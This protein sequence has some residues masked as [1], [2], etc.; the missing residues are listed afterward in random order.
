MPPAA[1]HSLYL[2]LLLTAGASAAEG[3]GSAAE[4]LRRS[5]AFLDDP[6]STRTLSRLIRDRYAKTSAARDLAN[7]RQRYPEPKNAVGWNPGVNVQPGQAELER[8]T[9]DAIDA[10]NLLEAELLRMTGAAELIT[11]E[12]TDIPLPKRFGDQKL[13]AGFDPGRLPQGDRTFIDNRTRYPRFDGKVLVPVR[14]PRVNPK[15]DEPVPV[16]IYSIIDPAPAW[17]A[18]LDA[19]AS[20]LATADPAAVRPVLRA[21]GAVAKRDARA[22]DRFRAGLTPLEQWWVDH[23]AWYAAVAANSP[24]GR[25][26]DPRPEDPTPAELEVTDSINNY[27]L[28]MGLL[29]FVIDARL[30]LSARN[31]SA[32]QT[33]RGTIAHLEDDPAMR[34]AW[35]RAKA[36]GYRS[37]NISENI[38]AGL[39]GWAV[40][41]W[42]TDAAHHRV[43]LQVDKRVVGVGVDGKYVTAVLGARDESPFA[44]ML[45]P[46]RQLPEGK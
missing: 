39:S 16:I 29:P 23:L 15:A 8:L 6:D 10:H 20:D 41:G 17:R 19:V 35:D 22:V 4:R 18:Y 12:T 36:A 26:G 43:L 28:A 13:P 11:A 24:A 38:S 31:H 7:D 42:R 46:E 34:H 32:Y 44:Q 2:L 3:F 30:Q 27:R 37:T 9:A 21:I 5:V 14:S 1:R 33:R 25:A 45:R 40:W